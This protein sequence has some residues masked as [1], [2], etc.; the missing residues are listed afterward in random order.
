MTGTKCCKCENEAISYIRINQLWKPVCPDCKL[1]WEKRRK[2]HQKK[3]LEKG[4]FKYG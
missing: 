1:L 4:V 2:N 3:K